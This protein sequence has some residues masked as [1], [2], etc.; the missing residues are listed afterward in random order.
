[1]LFR[2]PGQRHKMAKYLGVVGLGALATIATNGKIRSSAYTGFGAET[3]LARKINDGIVS[4][5]SLNLIPKLLVG[6]DVKNALEDDDL[7]RA[8]VYDV[9]KNAPLWEQF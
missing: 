1:M 9:K 3:G 4:I 5:D 6:K 7:W 2:S 8:I